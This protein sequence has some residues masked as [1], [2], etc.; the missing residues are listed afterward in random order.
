MAKHN[1]WARGNVKRDLVFP[2]FFLAAVFGHKLNFD[3]EQIL[4]L[5]LVVITCSLCRCQCIRWPEKWKFSSNG[6]CF[7]WSFWHHR[8]QSIFVREGGWKSQ[9]NG[10]VTDALF[11]LLHSI[12]S[13]AKCRVRLAWLIK[14]SH[15][16]LFS[17]W[18]LSYCF[19]MKLHCIEC[20]KLWWRLTN[21]SPSPFPPPQ[22]IIFSV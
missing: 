12:V 20:A 10:L 18:S 5:P 9:N 17:T 4:F 7:D 6:S 16:F 21:S 1:S 13:R 19:P 3:S 2:L 8:R 11:L 22:K 14:P 15:K